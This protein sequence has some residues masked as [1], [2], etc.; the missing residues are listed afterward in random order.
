MGMSIKYS[1]VTLWFYSKKYI[2]HPHFWH[3]AAKSFA[4][5]VTR[6]IK[7]IF[8]MLTWWLCNLPLMEGGWLT[9]EPTTWLDVCPIP[10]TFRD[11]RGPGDWV[12]PTVANDFI[13]HVYYMKCPL[14]PKKWG[15]TETPGWGNRICHHAGPQT[16]QEQKLHY[17][18]SSPVGLS[19]CIL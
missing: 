8:V 18:G 3:R 15:F 19:I 12:Q 4:F 16:P 11:G 7:V 5:P 17:L 1:S 13:N 14:K 2:F 9:G 6:E 10:L